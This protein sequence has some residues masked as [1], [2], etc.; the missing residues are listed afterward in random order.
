[1]PAPETDY[2]F[3]KAQLWQRIGDDEYANPLVSEREELT[4]RWENKQLEMMNPL[5]Q[6]IKIDALVITIHTIPVGSIMWLGKAVDLPIDLDDITNL[7]EVVAYD[8][9][10]DVKSRAFRKTVG[11]KRY[12]DKLPTIQ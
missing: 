6:P 7:M 10:P 9:I 3:Q 11:L 2:R 5:G 8:D 1:M 12:T 4:V